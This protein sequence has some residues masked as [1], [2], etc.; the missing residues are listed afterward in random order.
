MVGIIYISLLSITFWAMYIVGLIS[1]AKALPLVHIESSFVVILINASI[2]VLLTYCVL[3]LTIK[4]IRNRD[5][6]LFC[7]G[8]LFTV[9]LFILYWYFALGVLVLAASGVLRL[10]AGQ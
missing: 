5:K 3:L 6:Q 10:D 2:A 4:Q 9:G 8:V 1:P 7:S